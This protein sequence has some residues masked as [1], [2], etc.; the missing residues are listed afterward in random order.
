M[1]GPSV[2]TETYE[3]LR[4]L[5]F[6]IAYRM[7]GSVSEAEDVVQE[8]LLRL[9]RAEDVEHPKA[10]VATVVTRLSID[11][12]R[13]A[14]VRRETYVGPW[15]PEPVL[16]DDRE[17]PEQSVALA[18]SVTL[19][20]MVLLE[21]LSPEERAVFLLREVFDHEYDEIAAML[22]MTP[23]NCRQ[24]FHRAKLHIADR[25]PRY[26]DTLEAKRPL[27]QPPDL[28]HGPAELAREA[29][30]DRVGGEPPA[31]TGPEEDELAEGAPGLPEGSAHQYGFAGAPPGRRI[32]DGL[33]PHTPRRRGEAL[34]EPVVER[35]SPPRAC[36]HD[37][38]RPAARP[39]DEPA[40]RGARQRHEL[41]QGAREPDLRRRRTA[42]RGE[43][44]GEE[45]TDL[46]RSASST[47]ATTSKRP[48]DGMR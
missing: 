5:A 39:E 44:I 2:T 25:R 42:E 14:R 29:G 23:A 19:A 4:P 26:H 12:L 16:T 40:A 38:R 11:E 30:R 17:E 13:S 22:D 10:F 15:L 34:T 36:C 45:T 6:S 46:H 21:T 24:L 35:R 8:S 18:E 32:R 41:A 28:L 27:V 47:S 43:Q 37:E 1:D 7:L 9:H 48:N 20:F 3:S 31:A 33:A